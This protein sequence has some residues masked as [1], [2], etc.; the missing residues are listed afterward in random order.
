MYALVKMFRY[1]YWKTKQQNY[2]YILTPNYLKVE[3]QY[4][5]TTSNVHYINNYTLQ[6]VIYLLNQIYSTKVYIYNVLN[7]YTH[8]MRDKSSMHNI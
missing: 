6:L 5:F 2:K 4:I 3:I 1:I 7:I 8:S